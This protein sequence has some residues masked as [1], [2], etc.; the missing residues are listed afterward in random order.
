MRQGAVAHR[1]RAGTWDDARA[2]EAVRSSGGGGVICRAY[3]QA[4]AGREVRVYVLVFFMSFLRA[5]P[6]PPQAL[7]RSPCALDATI[8]PVRLFPRHLCMQEVM[9]RTLVEAA[10]ARD[11]A[12]QPLGTA[13][14]STA[15]GEEVEPEITRKSR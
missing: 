11:R 14:R 15:G 4:R 1:G 9:M 6:T 5:K 12:H 10:S 7:E 13:C 3:V 2:A 8:T